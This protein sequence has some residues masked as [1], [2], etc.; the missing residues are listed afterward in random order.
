MEDEKRLFFA[1]EVN[2]PWP[3]KLPRGR[4][5]HPQERHMTLA[6]LGNVSFSLIKEKISLIPPLPLKV[7]LVGF[8]TSCLL[9]PPR[10]PH[11]V[12]WEFSFLDD[13]SSLLSFR[14]ALL[15]WLKREE[16]PVD[17]HEGPFLAHVTIARAPFAKEEWQRA[18][19]ERPLT[20]GSLHLYE[21][22]GG[23]R[24]KPIWSHPL[25]SPFE[26]IEHTADLAF[27]I[28]G[29]TLQQIFQHA[30]VAL[31]FHFPSFLKFGTPDLHLETLDEIIIELNAMIT[32]A[33]KTIG[34][35]FKAVSFHGSLEK[36]EEVWL[37]EMIVDV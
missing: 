26:E 19:E 9:L 37:W 15:K 34:A 29:E 8:F 3:E 11:V 6:F 27:H 24:Y 33:D 5:L 12:A 28:R 17:I 4:L 25:K 16:L 20:L 7:G 18:F 36:E 23:L 22:L 10:R 32:R 35:P 2:A 21:S 30:K 13:P 1:L 14:D 31:S